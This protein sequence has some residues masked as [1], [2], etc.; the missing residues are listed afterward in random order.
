[1]AY[2][3]EQVIIVAIDFLDSLAGPPER[4]SSDGYITFPYQSRD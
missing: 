2:G 4:V 3:D 1:M